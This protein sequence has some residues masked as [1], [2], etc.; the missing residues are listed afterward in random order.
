MK[1]LQQRNLDRIAALLQEA[2][3]IYDDAGLDSSDSKVLGRALDTCFD[4]IEPTLLGSADA[5]D[6]V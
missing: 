2:Y 3:S 5:A 4:A 6:L 1:T